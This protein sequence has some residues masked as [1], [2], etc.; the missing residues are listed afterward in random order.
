MNSKTFRVL[1][2][3]V[4]TPGLICVDETD[5]WRRAQRWASKLVEFD[6]VTEVVVEAF[7]QDTKRCVR[8][9]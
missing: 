5:R 1:A 4:R 6:A 8:F 7:D 9:K 2:K 3:G